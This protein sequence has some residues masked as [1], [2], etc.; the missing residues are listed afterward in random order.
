VTNRPDADRPCHRRSRRSYIRSS[1]GDG[2][3]DGA[4][5]I[6]RGDLKR[7]G[8]RDWH[9]GSY[10]P[11]GKRQLL[12]L[13]VPARQSPSPAF[14]L[15]ADAPATCWLHSRS[16][17]CTAEQL[18]LILNAGS[19]SSRPSRFKGLGSNHDF[20]SLDLCPVVDRMKRHA[21]CLLL[22]TRTLARE[23]SDG[24][25]CRADWQ[26]SRSTHCIVL[27]KFA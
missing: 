24:A 13:K 22:M 1:R 7:A 19:P 14:G 18:P 16:E 10:S 12:R 26:S 11:E 3:L 4:S 20:Y 8:A 15:A 21:R 23:P 6:Q 17:A 5:A 25:D 27:V 2:G 9:S